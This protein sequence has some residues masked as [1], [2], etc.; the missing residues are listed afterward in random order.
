MNVV[1]QDNDSSSDDNE[2]V[3]GFKGS[4][5]PKQ[6]VV[7]VTINRMPVHAIIDT[8]ASINIMCNDVYTALPSRPALQTHEHSKV[9]AYGSTTPLEII[10]TFNASISY[11][12]TRITFTFFVTKPPGDTLIS[13]A[14]ASKLGIVKVVYTVNDN[15]SSPSHVPSL[16]EEYSDRFE[17]IGKLKD[18]QSKLNEDPTV[19]PIAQPHQR[20]PF[21]VR[22]KVDA[23][24]E[25][26]LSLDIIEPVHDEPTPWVSPIH[27]VEKPHRPGEIRMCVDMRPVNKAIQRERHVTPTIDDVIAHVN[28]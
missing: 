24:L 2:Y 6:P 9:F 21:H 5:K 4:P 20:I 13:F 10:G 11:K 14:S 3:F 7:T 22:K 28:D 8:G 27:V 23:E 15:P 12:S 26:L 1:N 17:G 16:V 25:K 18:F 19:Q